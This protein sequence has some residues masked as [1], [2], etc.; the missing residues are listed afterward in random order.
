MG[1]NL[2]WSTGLTPTWTSIVDSWWSEID[3]YVYGPS[4]NNC[5]QPR[6]AV[7]HF[8][9]VAWQCSV[10][11]GCA[12]ATCGS[13]SIAVCN[14]GIA[15]NLFD[16]L[17]FSSSVS[18]ALGKSGTSCSGGGQAQTC[19]AP[20]CLGGSSPST[21]LTPITPSRPPGYPR[22]L[23]SAVRVMQETRGSF[24]D[25]DGN[26]LANS[27]CQFQIV[28]S[29]PIVLTFDSL[30][31]EQNYDFIRVYDGESEQSPV[32]ATVTGTAAQPITSSGSLFI[33][34]TSDGS[35]EYSGF[36]ASYIPLTRRRPAMALAEQKPEQDPIWQRTPIV[37]VAVVVGLIVIATAVFHVVRLYQSKSEQSP[38]R[39][40]IPLPDRKSVV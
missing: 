33:V 30:D 11:V 39:C 35:V 40:N 27:A 12:M 1:E 16:A 18:V 31:L 2:Y 32:L 7:G 26:Y 9:Q 36:V 14:Y 25:G 20:Q 13:Q 21:P 28:S 24:S 37:A 4:G 22:C 23:N 19:S 10:Y 15:G 6:S 34:F 29:V 5:S 38:S 17:P 3:N 8:T